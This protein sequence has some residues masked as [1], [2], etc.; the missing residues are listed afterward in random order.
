MKQVIEHI[1]DHAEFISELL[2][3]RPVLVPVKLVC[4]KC[5]F[6]VDPDCEHKCLTMEIK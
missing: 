4:T 1:Q 3:G 5:T 2:G 6:P